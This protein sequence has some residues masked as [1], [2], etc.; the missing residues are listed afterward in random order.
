M[1]R[2][3]PDLED[4]NEPP[5]TLMM[6]IKQAMDVAEGAG[7]RAEVVPSVMAAMLVGIRV[8]TEEILKRTP[9]ESIAAEGTHGF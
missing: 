1:Q 5:D 3:R 9:L 6:V 8:A 2:S 4:Y 7:E